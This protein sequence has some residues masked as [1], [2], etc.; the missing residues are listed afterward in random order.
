ML[1]KRNIPIYRVIERLNNMTKNNSY[2]RIN[3]K[4]LNMKIS[5]Y[6]ADQINPD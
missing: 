2:Y 4:A 3:E 6:I 5:K 1:I